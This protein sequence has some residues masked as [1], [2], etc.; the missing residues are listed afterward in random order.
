MTRKAPGELLEDSNSMT[1]FRKAPVGLV[2][3]GKWGL[4]RKQGVAEAS[5]GLTPNHWSRVSC[6]LYEFYRRPNYLS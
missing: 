3:K 4:V 1:C 6:L 5:R 2:S